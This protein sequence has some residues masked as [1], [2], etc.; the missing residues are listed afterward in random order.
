MT[1][2]NL[3]RKHGVPKWLKRH[4]KRYDV[5]VTTIVANWRKYG[6]G[7]RVGERKEKR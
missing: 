3:T 5:D 2:N 1:E 6:E 4:T 7:K